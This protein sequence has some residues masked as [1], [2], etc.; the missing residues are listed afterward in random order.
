MRKARQG[1]LV[2][3]SSDVVGAVP[4]PRMSAYTTSKYALEAWVM[5]LQSELEGTGVRASVVRP[6]P[7]Q[8]G[9]ADGWDPD[10][11]ASMFTE[12]NERRV[13]RHWGLLTAEDVAAAIATVI[14][15][16]DHVHLRLVDVA[17]AVPRVGEFVG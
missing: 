15:A 13:M 3:V 12:W 4:R 7:T 9:H 17:P 14:S 1:D 6:G 16:P 8:T 2:F 11:M 5:V 10:E